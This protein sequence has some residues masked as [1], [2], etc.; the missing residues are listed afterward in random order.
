[1]KRDFAVLAFGDHYSLVK[2][3]AVI[4][5]EE[6][7]VSTVPRYCCY[8]DM[9]EAI[10]K[11]HIDQEGHSRIRKTEN[12]V[13]LHYVNISRAMIEIFIASCSCQLDWYQLK[14]VV[15]LYF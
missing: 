9:F 13:Q 14:I 1:L 3:R 4:G 12:S 2:R 5:K 15:T 6:V 11:C 10:S 8:E 7:D